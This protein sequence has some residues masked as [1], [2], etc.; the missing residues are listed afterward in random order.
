MN[1]DVSLY[2][3][4]KAWWFSIIVMLMNSGGLNNLGMLPPGAPGIPNRQVKV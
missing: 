4:L 2:L 3:L 1:E